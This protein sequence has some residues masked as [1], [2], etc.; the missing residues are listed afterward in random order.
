MW[1]LAHKNFDKFPKRIANSPMCSIRITDLDLYES[2]MHHAGL[3]GKAETAEWPREKALRLLSKH[4]G[5][6]QTHWHE[7]YV[8]KLNSQNMIFIRF[9][10]SNIVL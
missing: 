9:S 6:N 10:T 3:R 8:R 7:R 1:R 2:K 4:L 5:S